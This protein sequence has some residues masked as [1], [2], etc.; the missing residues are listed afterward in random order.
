[1]GITNNWSDCLSLVLLA[2]SKITL[3]RLIISYT[4]HFLKM[5]QLIAGPSKYRV[6]AM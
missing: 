3:Q 2:E 4:Y 1:M 5:H 6:Y